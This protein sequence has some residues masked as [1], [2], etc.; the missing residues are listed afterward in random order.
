MVHGGG[1]TREE[2]GFFAR[3]AAWLGEAS[4][5]SLRFDLRGHGESEG[6]PAGPANSAPQAPNDGSSRRTEGWTS[7]PCSSWHIV[8]TGHLWPHLS[9]ENWPHP[10]RFGPTFADRKPGRKLALS[11]TSPPSLP[12]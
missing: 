5:T 11:G 4:V 7:R 12:I 2:D 10:A 3:L 8:S 6:L 9:G 1:V